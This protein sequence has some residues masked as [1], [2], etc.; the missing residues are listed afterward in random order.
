MKYL[1]IFNTLEEYKGASFDTPNVGYIVEDNAVKYNNITKND[2]TVIWYTS[3][4]GIVTPSQAAVF[5]A[6]LL[7][8]TYD[9]DNDLGKLQFDG[10]VKQI[11]TRAFYDCQSLTSVTIPNSVTSIGDWAFYECELTSVAIP[12]KVKSIGQGAFSLCESLLSVTIP[13][14]VTSMGSFAFDDCPSLKSVTIGS[15][16]TNIGDGAFANCSDLTTIICKA[17]D[18]PT[19]VSTLQGLS[20]SLIVYVPVESVEAYRTASNWCELPI[21]PIP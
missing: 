13:D 6:T 10:P 20:L 9:T 14:S 4:D 18:P 8:N 21:Q 15:G 19:L 7:S 3:D 16:V 17:V 1:K 2:N 12:N 11:G 5:G